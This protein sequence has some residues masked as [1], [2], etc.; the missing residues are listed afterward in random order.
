MKILFSL[1]PLNKRLVT[2]SIH[3]IKAMLDRSLFE[4]D[5]RVT[6]AF[7]DCAEKIKEEERERE[8]RKKE[9]EREDLAS[10]MN[11]RYLLRE[12]QTNRLSW[13]ACGNPTRERILSVGRTRRYWELLR[14]N[15]RQRN[16]CALHECTY[17][18]YS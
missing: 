7:V 13:L 4:I 17:P 11:Q 5:V 2:S 6:F 8:D 10:K 14:N 15:R 18:L 1:K 3:H 16:C 12:M 9:R